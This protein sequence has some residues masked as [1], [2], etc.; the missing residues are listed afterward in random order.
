MICHICSELADPFAKAKLLG[1]YDIQ[2]FQC[3]SCGFVQT[4]RP[5]WLGEVYSSAINNSDIGLISRNISFARSTRAV[6]LAFFNS[7]ARFMDYGGGY[8]L[9]VRMMRDLGIDFY[10]SDKFCENLFAK[11]FE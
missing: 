8:G 3:K 6:I 9:F 10:W 7:D 1:K 5:Y 11:G 2:Y 4:E